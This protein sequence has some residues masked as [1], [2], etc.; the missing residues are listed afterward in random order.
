MTG[1]EPAALRAA[2]E[3]AL[4]G[5]LPLRRELHRHPEIGLEL[6]ETQARIAAELRGL[7]LEPRF[8]KGLSSVVAVIEPGGGSGSGA[9]GSGARGTRAATILRADMDALP[10]QEATGLE[11]ASERPG[12]MHA[13]GHDTHMTMLL[14]AARLLVE[15]RIA[16]P[17]PVIL[18]FQ[19]GEEGF[20]G[21]KLML[22]EGLLEGLD[23]ATARAFALHIWS[24]LPSG[25]IHL[26]AGAQMASAD[27]YRIILT[28]RGG[29]A[30]KPHLAA[31]PIPAAAEIVIG[32]QVAL[33]REVDIFD[34]AVLTITQVHAGT[35]HN[36]IPERAFLE[37]T[38]RTLS[39]ARRDATVALIERVAGSIAARHRLGVE[40][41]LDIAYPPTINDPGVVE[42]VANLASGLI[43][44][45]RVVSMAAPN[46]AGEDWSYVLQQVPGAMAFLGAR[47][48]GADPATVPDNHSNRV[49]FDEPAMVVGG[50]LYAAF[51]LSGGRAP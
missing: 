46:M 33:N 15:R 41:E 25:E 48:A 36:I 34:P 35:T 43:G 2:A 10:L 32:L 6:P 27:S 16:L 50:A 49:V 39:E 18:M 45:D 51:A 13:C 28:G 8:G 47:P 14:L 30:S 42:V 21:A 26:R 22:D 19:P 29:H 38:L 4:P 7:G 24:S 44:P 37:G 1:F 9:R 11:F 20:A 40:F 31:D 23:S 17:G 12:A 3:A 5:L